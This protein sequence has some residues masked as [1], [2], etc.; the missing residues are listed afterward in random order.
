MWPGRFAIDI[1]WKVDHA[2]CSAVSSPSGLTGQWARSVIYNNSVILNQR[3]PQPNNE[4]EWTVRYLHSPFAYLACKC[5]SLPSTHWILGRK[6]DG[7]MS[8]E[9]GFWACHNDAVE[10]YRPHV[11][12]QNVSSVSEDLVTSILGSKQPVRSVSYA[13]R[14]IQLRRHR[15]RRTPGAGEC[16]T[17]RILSLLRAYGMWIYFWQEVVF[18]IR[19]WR[20]GINFNGI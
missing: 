8:E 14:L 1:S 16:H 13:R 10:D 18:W 20:S 11:Y 9:C 7:S 19:L 3:L 2:W 12:W 6:E 4:R 17:S 15:P 5:T